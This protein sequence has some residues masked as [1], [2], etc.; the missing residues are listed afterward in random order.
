LRALHES[1]R[2]RATEQAE[3][4]GEEGSH[5]TS[6]A[7]RLRETFHIRTRSGV[8]VEREASGALS[9]SGD[10]TSAIETA[11]NAPSARL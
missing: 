10:A 7:T 11:A 4:E 9:G 1:G 3:N 5:R 8:A 6:L 2:A